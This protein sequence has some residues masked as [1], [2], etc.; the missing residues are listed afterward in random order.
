MYLSGVQNVI[1]EKRSKTQRMGSETIER[2]NIL[3]PGSCMCGHKGLVWSV[4]CATHTKI[5]WSY[6]SSFSW[7]VLHKQEKHVLWQRER[8]KKKANKD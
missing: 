4:V 2:K 1:D 3:E 8:K 7:K 6:H 5:Y